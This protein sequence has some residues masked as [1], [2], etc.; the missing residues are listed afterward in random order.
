MQIETTPATDKLAKIVIDT[1]G[2]YTEHNYPCPVCQ[3][4][5]AVLDTTEG[6]FKP[7]WDCQRKGFVTL[8]INPK[9]RWQKFLLSLLQK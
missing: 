1:D 4:Q 9:S 6:V 7:C 3:T 8:E 5:H 2:L